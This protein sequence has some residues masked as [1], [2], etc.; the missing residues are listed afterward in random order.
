[1]QQHTFIHLVSLHYYIDAGQDP[2]L[3][4]KITEISSA[5]ITSEDEPAN[6]SGEN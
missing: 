2:M 1:M 5:R 3:I 4:S 6:N